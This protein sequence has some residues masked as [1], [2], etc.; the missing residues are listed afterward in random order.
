M[1]RAYTIKVGTTNA[2]SVFVD[3]TPVYC[4]YVENAGVYTRAWRCYIGSCFHHSTCCTTATK[5]CGDYSNATCLSFFGCYANYYYCYVCQWLCKGNCC[6]YNTKY[7]TV[8]IPANTRC[9]SAL[10]AT[11]VCSSISVLYG[12]TSTIC[13]IDY[14]IIG[15]GCSVSCNYNSCFACCKIEGEKCISTNCVCSASPTG[16]ASMTSHCGNIFSNVEVS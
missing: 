6:S 11:K 1:S 4:C 7:N 3:G 14:T 5:R 16:Y 8:D 13:N 15:A 10:S 9:A 12:S 2:S